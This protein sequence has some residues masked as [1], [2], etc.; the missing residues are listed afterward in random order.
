MSERF[1]RVSADTIQYEATL[2]D[3]KTWTGYGASSSIVV[4]MLTPVARRV[5]SRILALNRARAFGAIVRVT[6]GPPASRFR[7][8]RFWSTIAATTVSPR[9]DR[10]PPR[11]RQE[12][13]C[14]QRPFSG[15]IG[16]LE[17]YSAPRFGGKPTEA[18]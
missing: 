4:S 13:L 14:I 16:L 11:R 7:P 6:F 5:M 9:P 1:T 12:T 3:P 10:S 15:F 2:D 18:I 17:V 8:M